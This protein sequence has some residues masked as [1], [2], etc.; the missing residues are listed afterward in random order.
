[1]LALLQLYLPL[2]NI[3]PPWNFMPDSHGHNT[4]T[5]VISIKTLLFLTIWFSILAWI[6]LKASPDLVSGLVRNVHFIITIAAVAI[7]R[8]DW[9]GYSTDT[10][11]ADFLTATRLVFVLGQVL[12]LSALLTNYLRHRN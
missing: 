7:A 1:M 5:V 9:I 4:Y 2:A 11:H 6:Y 10:P 3:L 12:L 8:R